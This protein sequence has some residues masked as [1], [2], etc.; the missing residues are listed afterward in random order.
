MKRFLVAMALVLCVGQVQAVEY[1]ITDLGT[2]GLDYSWAQG[3]NDSGQVVGES[4]LASGLNRAF[5]Y[6]TGNMTDLGTLGGDESR[7]HGINNSGQV[8]GQS[9][10]ASGLQRAVLY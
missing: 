10:N 4:R 5:L 6:E 2:L 1:T 9:H 8:V 3:I 7:A